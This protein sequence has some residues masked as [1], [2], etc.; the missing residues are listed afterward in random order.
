MKKLFIPLI[1][2]TLLFS[3]CISSDTRPLSAPES[4]LLLEKKD[5]RIL[6]EVKVKVSRRNILGLFSFGGGG[7]ED[8]LAKAREVYPESDSV[9][10]IYE[11][12]SSSLY[13]GIYNSITTTLIG[14]AIDIKDDDSGRAP[15]DGQTS[16]K[17]VAEAP[18]EAA[19]DAL[20]D[21]VKNVV[22]ENDIPV[23]ED[24]IDKIVG[25]II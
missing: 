4:S 11:D 22:K 13:F 18:V 19:V 24:M 8:L 21:Q 12:I 3:S 17:D 5:F 25:S 10:N 20:T 16:L 9:V 14:T 6:G 7:Y 23:S 2:S 1:I 15:A